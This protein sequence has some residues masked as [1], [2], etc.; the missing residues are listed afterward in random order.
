M[1]TI[2]QGATG[3]DDPHARLRDRYRAFAEREARGVSPLYEALARAVAGSEA[4]LGFV[5]SLPPPKQQPN[6]VFG[7]VRH[8]YGTPRDPG[9]F[10]RLVE[11]HA[12]PIRALVLRRSTQTNEPARCAT[13]L[14]ALAMLPGPLALLEV[15]ASAG[16]CLLPDRYAYDYGRVRLH[17]RGVDAPPVFPCAASGNTPLPDRLPEIGWRAGIDLDPVNVDDADQAAWLETLVWPGQEARA[18]RLRA[19]MAVARRDPP[20]VTAGDLVRDLRAVAETAPREATLV[21]FHSAVLAYVAPADRVRFA[22]EVADLGATWISNE[23]P[24][25]LPQV[26]S[27]LDGEPPPGRFVLAVNGEPVAFTGPHGR[28]I[29]WIG[30]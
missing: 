24:G 9:H 22:R 8:L 15:G 19:A 7:A 23:S 4:L 10:A 3:A 18:E 13:L 2:E 25:V 1:A 17:P 16:L 21:I 28:S 30:G 27:K 6:L 11:Q 26:A 5:A 12:E 20:R 14:P 29:D